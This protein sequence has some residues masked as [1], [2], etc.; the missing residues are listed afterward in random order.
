MTSTSPVLHAAWSPRS[1][2]WPEGSDTRVREAI[3]MLQRR[4]SDRPICASV[5][6]CAPDSRGVPDG[7]LEGTHRGRREEFDG[8]LRRLAHVPISLT[9]RRQDRR[10]QRKQCGPPA[11][12]DSIGVSH[13]YRT[14][15]AILHHILT[16][17]FERITPADLYD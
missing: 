12:A 15:E 16:R 2:L 10:G 14:N 3:L 5:R 4:C 9:S 1:N 7:A 6:G 8:A 17:I 13:S 11:R